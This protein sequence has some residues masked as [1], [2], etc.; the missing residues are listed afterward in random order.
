VEVSFFNDDEA[1]FQETVRHFL[2]DF[3]R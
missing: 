3:K 1:L 2:L